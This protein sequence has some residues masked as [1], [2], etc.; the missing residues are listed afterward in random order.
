MHSDKYPSLAWTGN[1]YILQHKLATTVVAH[2]TYPI[3]K[4]PTVPAVYANLW[5]VQTLRP[6][7]DAWLISMQAL[8]TETVYLMEYG[9]WGLAPST[10]LLGVSLCQDYAYFSLYD[11][12]LALKIL[13]A[14]LL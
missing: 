6:S 14:F 7:D 1:S 12:G 3:I 10:V 2:H 4:E 8:P 9:Y 11:D 13:V 5:K